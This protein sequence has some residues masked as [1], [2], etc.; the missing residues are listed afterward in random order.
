MGD[1]RRQFPII[2][3]AQDYALLADDAAHV[4]YG[5]DE[6]DDSDRPLI[7]PSIE[8]EDV[9]GDYPIGGPRPH[10]LT[11]SR[12][13][14]A[15][16]PLTDRLSRLQFTSARVTGGTTPRPSRIDIAF[17]P[18]PAKN[19]EETGDG[20][21]NAPA[22]PL[23][24]SH[25][26]IAVDTNSVARQIHRLNTSP[27]RPPVLRRRDVL[28]EDFLRQNVSAL[29]NRTPLRSASFPIIQL[30]CVDETRHISHRHHALIQSSFSIPGFTPEV[31]R[32][33]LYPDDRGW[34]QPYSVYIP[35]LHRRLWLSLL[36]APPGQAATNPKSNTVVAYQVTRLFRTA[37]SRHR[38]GIHSVHS[39]RF[40]RR[41][42]HSMKRR[43]AAWRDFGTTSSVRFALRYFVEARRRYL[44][45]REENPSLPLY[46]DS[47]GMVAPEG[48]PYRKA[49][50]AADGW[51]AV[52]DAEEEAAVVGV[53]I[54]PQV[55]EQHCPESDRDEEAETLRARSRRAEF[56]NMPESESDEEVDE[57]W[58]RDAA[59]SQ[60]IFL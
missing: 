34:Q 35:Y 16:S 13:V 2:G 1:E 3:P 15:G 56:E 8:G 37:L 48:H 41:V 30:S 49:Q 12:A 21:T 22:S 42:S 40:A 33:E 50:E 47:R 53:L 44:A 32:R 31:S 52:V 28:Y 45:A 14:I 25:H 6:S 20:P 55:E 9:P 5:S 24:R 4:R 54:D 29:I 60:P 51:I 23:P 7:L 58:R 11:L 18:P 19:D 38:L 26:G 10:T 59:G 39:R 17:T 27:P 57:W 36:S 43:D 46:A